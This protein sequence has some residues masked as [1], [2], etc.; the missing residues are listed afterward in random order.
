M[1]YINL[2][3][4]REEQRQRQQ[5][6]YLAVLGSVAAVTFVA[7]W[8]EDIFG[9]HGGEALNAKSIVIRLAHGDEIA[10]GAWRAT[11]NLE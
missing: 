8:G 1:A 6:A 7:G 2:L 3:P 10:M 11:V 5:K 4:W 9:L